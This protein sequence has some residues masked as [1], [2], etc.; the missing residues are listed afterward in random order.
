MERMGELKA[1]FIK[2]HGT[3]TVASSAYLA[4]GATAAVITT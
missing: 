4:D 2:P 1:A 3:I